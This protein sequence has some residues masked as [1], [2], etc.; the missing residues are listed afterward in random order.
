MK[1]LNQTESPIFVIL[2]FLCFQRQSFFL[3]LFYSTIAG[4]VPC[5]CRKKAS[6]Y[7]I[8]V[9]VIFYFLW[10][11]WAYPGYFEIQIPLKPAL[12]SVCSL[13]NYSVAYEE[14]RSNRVPYIRDFLCSL[15]P[16]AVLFYFY[17]T[18]ERYTLSTENLHFLLFTHTTN[19]AERYSLSTEK[20]QPL[21]LTNTTNTF[22]VCVKNGSN[23]EN[24][25]K[26]W[27]TI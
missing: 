14:T 13:A 9:Q 2:C 18:A 25:Q 17:F 26:I 21:L 6:P 10:D 7:I 16:K 11:Y 19:T 22:N 4:V 23:P 1:R 8:I 20:P 5:G 3:L 12:R 24:Y 15:F 27:G